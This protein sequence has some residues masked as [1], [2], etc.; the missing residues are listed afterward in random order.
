MSFLKRALED[1]A[2]ADYD[3]KSGKLAERLSVELLI[4]KYGNR[5]K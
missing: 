1:C 2:R 3:I 5:K 4:V